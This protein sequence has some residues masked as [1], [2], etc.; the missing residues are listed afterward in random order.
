MTALQD[1]LDRQGENLGLTAEQNAAL[2]TIFE[3]LGIAGQ[4]VTAQPH[5]TGI[6]WVI[7]RSILTADRAMLRSAAKR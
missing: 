2:H 1:L 6:M 4:G 3:A 5:R 7:G